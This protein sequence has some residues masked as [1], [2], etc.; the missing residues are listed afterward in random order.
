MLIPLLTAAFAA[1]FQAAP[2][3]TVA[4]AP[5]GV[6]TR[7]QQLAPDS[8]RALRTARRAQDNFEFIRRQYLPHEYGI[9]SHA[10]DVRIGRWCIWNEGSGARKAPP[11][12][13]RIIEAR[14]R[15]LVLLDSVGSQFPGDEWIAAQQIRY[16]I[17][18]KRFADAI[19]VAD[20]CTESGSP[21]R[22]RAFA[23]VAFHDSGAVYAADSA[24][25]RALAAMPD[26]IR[27][28]WTDISPLI[29]D[30]LADRYDHADCALRRAIE[31]EFWSITTPLYLRESDFHD[32]F[33]SRVVRTV[34]EENSR[35]PLGSPKEDAFREMALRY[36]DDTWFSR[37]D[38]PPG[39]MA[40]PVVSGHSENGDGFNFVPRYG[41]FTSP[42][43]LSA[44][45][46][47]L[48]L[49][50]ARTNYA[51]KYAQHFR[52]LERR[53][54]ALFRRGDSAL[55]VA[56]YDASADTLF[57][58]DTLEAGLFTLAVNGTHIG[59]PRGVVKVLASPRE[60]L[61]ATAAWSPMLVSLELLDDSTRSAARLRYGLTPPLAV[62]RVSISD[63]LMFRP[64]SG[65]A[66]TGTLTDV[67]PLM[68][69]DLHVSAKE[70]LGV[71][72]ETYGVRA[73]GENIAVALSIERIKE[74]WARRAAERLHLAT[75]FSPM[76]VRWQEIPNQA[77]H[78]ASR[79]MTL[80]LSKL[81]PGRYEIS[82][83]LSPRGEPA[84]VAKREIVIER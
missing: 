81:D 11:E 40:E 9:G 5:G 1:L 47:D 59:E 67:L 4:V 42:A 32:E 27:C 23:G 83:T 64:P 2:S 57:L 30:D 70:P 82:L 49:R 26:S 53:Q 62:G 25:S 39:S 45:D 68:L 75:P 76:H 33:L 41:V 3:Q 35:T 13:P 20:R 24:F 28:R 38:A 69:H 80:D 84:V 18:A 31:A 14:A 21:Y 34:M 50:S 8:L 16:M 77:D 22:C 51:P 72:W 37:E 79:S 15:L 73:E 60:V 29:D 7:V 66:T 36:G 55:V 12:A 10:C 52:P 78:V 63:L 43:S 71:F 6:S 44:D 61:T 54:I 17:E 19:R 65:D 58:H 56:A 46:W 48:Q 74:G